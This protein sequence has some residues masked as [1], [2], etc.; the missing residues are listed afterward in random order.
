M[1][2][3]REDRLSHG[4]GL[5]AVIVSF[6][7]TR[8]VTVEKRTAD[9]SAELSRAQ[10]SAGLPAVVMGRA[11][12]AELVH[13]LKLKP[14]GV[15]SVPSKL[16]PFKARSPSRTARSATLAAST[17]E[18]SAKSAPSSQ[19]PIDFFP[20]QSQLTPPGTANRVLTVSVLLELGCDTAAASC[21]LNFRWELTCLCCHR[22]DRPTSSGTR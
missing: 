22:C 13:G 1:A 21:E 15:L 18:Q 3:P 4:I 7:A 5:W 14:A 8:L 20:S 17:V 6:M 16:Q 9:M 19:K 10:H 12:S 2:L 11:S